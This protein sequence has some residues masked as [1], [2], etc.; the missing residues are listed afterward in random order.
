M[1][2]KPFSRKEL[3]LIKQEERL[4]GLV[5]PSALPSFL[6]QSLFYPTRFVDGST[7]NFEH[8]PTCS[9]TSA[10]GWLACMMVLEKGLMTNTWTTIFAVDVLH[11]PIFLQGPQ[12]LLRV[13]FR[14]I[15]WP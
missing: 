12:A 1:L 4:E 2:M 15:A 11:P 13:D 6:L 5:W 7:M 8:G 3:C 9:T 14:P 10:I